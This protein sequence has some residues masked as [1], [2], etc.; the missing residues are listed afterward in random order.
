MRFF[1]KKCMGSL[2]TRSEC[3]ATQCRTVPRSCAFAMRE[4][5]GQDFCTAVENSLRQ[6]VADRFAGCRVLRQRGGER[7]FRRADRI[8]SARPGGAWWPTNA[9]SRIQDTRVPPSDESGLARPPGPRAATPEHAR[10]PLPRP[11]GQVPW[12]PAAGHE[13]AAPH[14]RDL[15]TSLLLGAPSSRRATAPATARAARLSAASA[16]PRPDYFIHAAGAF[17][18]D[19]APACPP[20]LGLTGSPHRYIPLSDR[21][22][23]LRM[24]HLPLRW[25]GDNPL[26]A[27]NL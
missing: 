24:N 13:Q 23:K 7:V 18:R 26:F 8:S 11:S 27:K 14:G 5:H 20:L 12:G 6:L 3:R 21:D 9:P 25:C 4:P 22:K 10:L 19:P 2:A 1:E 16:T 17:S 15:F